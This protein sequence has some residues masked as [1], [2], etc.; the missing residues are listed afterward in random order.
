CGLVL[1]RY[2][3]T[4]VALVHRN[5][6]QA[7]PIDVGALWESGHGP[8]SEAGDWWL[9]LPVDVAASARTSIP[10]G[11]DPPQEHNQKATSD[12]IDASGNRVIHVGELTL[13]VGRTNLKKA[14]ERPARDRSNDGG[15][16]I[17]HS[18][19]GASIAIDK[20]G[21]ITISAKQDLELV[22]EQGNIKL[23]A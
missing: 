17:Q 21:K 4:R 18:D 10:D 2:P 20:N 1:P 15:I 8:D 5:G 19:G 3:G 7:D 23:T 13:T 11:E 6:V 9:I 14:G 16:T 12:L 22:S